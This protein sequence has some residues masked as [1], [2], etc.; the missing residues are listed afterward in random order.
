MG[1]AARTS[2]ALV[3]LGVTGSKSLNFPDSVLADKTVVIVSSL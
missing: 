3:A 2:T 1:P